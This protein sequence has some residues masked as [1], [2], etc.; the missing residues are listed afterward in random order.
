MKKLKVLQQY[1]NVNL[2]NNFIQPSWLSAEALIFF[3][4]KSDRDLQLC[5][6]YQRLN[7]IIKKNWYSL[8][9]IDKIMNCVSDTKIFMKIDIK[10][11][12]YYIHICE[13][14]EWK[15]V[16]W[17]C[18]KLYKYLI[19]SFRLINAS[20]SFQFYIYKVLCEYLNIFVIVFL[21]DI[22]IYSMKKSK[23]KQHIQTVL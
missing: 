22:L 6:N 12:Y 11:I 1:L 4:L 13:G 18:Y 19:M 21:N 20:V 17:T 7:T 14:D 8:S 5:V 9:L 10:N 23:H 16:F 2:K 15:T 3:T